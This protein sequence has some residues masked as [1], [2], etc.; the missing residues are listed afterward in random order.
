ML[1]PSGIVPTQFSSISVFRSFQAS[2]I[3]TL[4]LIVLNAFSTKEWAILPG[5]LA[6]L[7]GI[8][9]SVF[10]HASF[11]HL[12]NNM[13]PLLG[14]LWMGL[15]FYGN[16]IVVPVI[17]G[18][19]GTGTFVWIF[20]S[21]TYHLGASGLVFCLVTYVFTRGILSFKLIPII[22]SIILLTLEPEIFVDI[23]DAIINS[24]FAGSGGVSYESHFAGALFG[25]IT[26]IGTRL[27]VSPK[28]R[29]STHG[30]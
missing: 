5:H 24:S 4:I 16:S 1:S 9:T 2:V 23:P 10:A 12:I 19:I 21:D 28:T 30:K 6:F 15:F 8:L 25:I 11:A 22:G 29:S 3:I 18:W 13:I 20:G 26:A 27:A 17:V 14:V 7:S